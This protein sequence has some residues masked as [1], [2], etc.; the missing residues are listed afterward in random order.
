MVWSG[1]KIYVKIQSY[2]QRHKI[3]VLV[4]VFVLNYTWLERVEASRVST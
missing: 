4:L 1:G 3:E 2:R